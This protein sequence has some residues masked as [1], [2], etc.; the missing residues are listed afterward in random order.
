MK[1]ILFLTIFIFSAHC[2]FSQQTPTDTLHW[3]SS[4]KLQWKDFA[5]KP[6]SKGGQF[7]Q[8][9]MQVNAYFKKGIKMK[10]EVVTIFDR[11]KSY[12]EPEDKTPEILKYYQ[13]MFDL[14]EVESRKLRKKFSETKF[15][16]DPEKKFQELYKATL[17]ELEKRNDLYM[18]ETETGEKK[19]AVQ[20]W[21]KMIQEELKSL[22]AFK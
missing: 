10:T 12:S 20:H 17:A 8:A 1:N 14:H 7:G 21:T 5:A 2:S 9:T 4:Y 15:G 6:D 11:K 13:T 19:E 3:N 18:E 16:I 22:E